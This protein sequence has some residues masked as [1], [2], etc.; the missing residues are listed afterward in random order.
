MFYLLGSVILFSINNLLWAH[1][2][3]QQNIYSIIK[4][5]AGFTSLFLGLLLLGF[6]FYSQ[7]EFPTQHIIELLIIS[8]IGFAGLSC[9][10]L[11][12]KQ[13]SFLQYAIYSLLFTYIIGF[14]LQEQ[15]FQNWMWNSISLA[16]VSLGYLYFI[17]KQFKETKTQKRSKLAHLYFFLAHL[18][19]ATLL[20]LQ[21]KFLENS[22]QLA[23]AF[24]QEF[25]VFILAGLILW[26]KPDKIKVKQ[27][28]LW[29]FS[30]FA[31]PITLAV[32]LGL[33]GL[34]STNPFHSALIGLL[35]PIITLLLGVLLKK[36]KLNLKSLPGLII[37][38]VGMVSF[39]MYS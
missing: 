1:F 3:P 19:F 9:L 35:V 6:L 29:K 15:L 18:C 2:A 12:F 27:I 38:L 10:V 17:V 26:L 21:W 28:P 31:L 34:K 13:G 36:E 24:T 33:E 4:K 16:F 11:G 37:M 14:I 32:L 22:S 8:C 30:L 20:F 39:Y 7:Q 25:S 5:R 23:I